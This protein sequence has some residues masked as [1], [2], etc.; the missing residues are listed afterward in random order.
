MKFRHVEYLCLKHFII[1]HPVWCIQ[2]ENQQKQWYLKLLRYSKY[3]VWSTIFG[4]RDILLQIMKRRLQTR[5]QK[6]RKV[7]LVLCIIPTPVC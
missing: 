6:T 3:R 1:S 2:I 4:M 7:H 5:F